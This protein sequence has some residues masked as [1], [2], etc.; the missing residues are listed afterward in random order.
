MILN[1]LFLSIPPSLSLAGLAVGIKI[2]GATLLF[3]LV[4][5]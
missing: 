4:P 5:G 1:A 2:S 3:F